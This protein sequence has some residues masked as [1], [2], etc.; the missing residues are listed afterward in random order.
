LGGKQEKNSLAQSFLVYPW[1]TSSSPAGPRQG[2]KKTKVCQK[3]KGALSTFWG[4][5]KGEGQR[6]STGKHCV[7]ARKTQASSRI[8]RQSLPREERQFRGRRRER[9]CRRALCE[10]K[11]RKKDTTGGWKLVHKG[12]LPGCLAASACGGGKL[13]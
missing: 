13:W 3:K 6:G 1:A 8:K 2:K 7:G 4:G 11:R 5:A 9:R 12:V 10:L